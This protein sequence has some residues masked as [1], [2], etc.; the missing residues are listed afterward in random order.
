MLSSASTVGFKE[1]G[2][3]RNYTNSVANRATAARPQ[4]FFQKI[5]R[6]CP[7]ALFDWGLGLHIN[8]CSNGE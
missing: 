1:R 2:G 6:S 4:V 3:R 5:V 8:S 7:K